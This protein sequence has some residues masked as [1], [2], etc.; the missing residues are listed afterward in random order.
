MMHSK[1]ILGHDP[2]NKVSLSLV[3]GKTVYVD[4][5]FHEPNMQGYLFHQFNSF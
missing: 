3:S 4:Y 5:G 1:A 2:M